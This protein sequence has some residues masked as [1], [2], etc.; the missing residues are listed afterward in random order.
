MFDGSTCLIVEIFSHEALSREWFAL[1][2][3]RRGSGAKSLGDFL[4]VRCEGRSTCE[5]EIM[6]IFQEL[7]S[8]P[9]DIATLNL[10]VTAGWGLWTRNKGVD[11][12]LETGKSVIDAFDF[13]LT[14]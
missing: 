4:R 9:D 8:S 11:G 1:K 2:S 7:R 12:L 6:V 14:S 13:L 3:H 5:R 10:I